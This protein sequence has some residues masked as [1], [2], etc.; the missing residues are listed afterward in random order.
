MKYNAVKNLEKR[1][2]M[3]Q[4]MEKL[5]TLVS[6]SEQVQYVSTLAVHTDKSKLSSHALNKLKLRYISNLH[7]H[8]YNTAV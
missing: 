5:I 4:N 7:C 2:L 8:Q 1:N 6:V 3:L